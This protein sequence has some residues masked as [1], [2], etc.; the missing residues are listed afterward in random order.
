MDVEPD[1]SRI[2]HQG[3]QVLSEEMCKH[4]GS[5][6]FVVDVNGATI[7]ARSAK[8]EA[9]TVSTAPVVRCNG[10]WCRNLPG[11]RNRNLRVAVSIET[12][13]DDRKA[14]TGKILGF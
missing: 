7:S 11:F 4:V 6:D 10:G 13:R 12:Q 1:A 9:D 8:H 5:E 14:L 3:A 2:G